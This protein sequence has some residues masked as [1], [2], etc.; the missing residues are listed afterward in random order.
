MNQKIKKHLQD[1]LATALSGVLEESGKKISE[2]ID[3]TVEV[4]KD[5]GHGDVSTNLA[6][7]YAKIAGVNPRQ[8][9]EVLCGRLSCKADEEF[10]KIEI[11]GPGFIN[12]TLSNSALHVMLLDV[13]E[14]G[15]EFCR[16]NL[17]KGKKILI[18]FVSANPTGPLTVAHGRQAAIGDALA[19]ILKK[20]GFEVSTEFYLNDRGKQISI[21]GESLYSRYMEICGKKYPFP[22]DGYRGGYVNTLARD[23]FDKEGDKYSRFDKEEA[24]EYMSLYSK[25]RIMQWI[26]EDLKNFNVEFDTYFSEKEFTGGGQVEESIKALKDKACLFEKDGA[27]WFK[28]TEFGDDKDR[29]VV[30]SNGEWTYIAPD[31][32]YHKDKLARE[33]DLLID[34][35]GPDHHG[36]IPRIKAAIEALGYDPEILKVIIIQLATLYKGGK[37]LSMSTRQGEFISLRDV[38]DE[39]GKDAARYFFVMRSNASHLDFDLELAKKQSPDNPVYYIQYTHARICSIFKKY[40]ERFKHGYVQVDNTEGLNPLVNYEEKEIMKKLALFPEAVDACAVLFEPHRMTVYLSELAA[41][42]HS[43][44]HKDAKKFRIVGDR[45]DETTLARMALVS[46]IRMVIS[47]GLNLLGISAPEKM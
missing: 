32:A 38:V 14:K 25:D 42:F 17:G 22:E 40:E 19:R 7:R 44:Y 10:E 9:A 47:S 23:L 18:E 46:A 8:L 15:T 43:Y 41:L 31:I 33:Y 20:A 11:A 26:K 12:I 27:V 35:F 45:E 13:L 37:K 1:I 36:Y 30:K 4:P 5:S 6:L 39:V 3:V 28:S 29:V 21:L 34:I 24:F 2:K 16:T